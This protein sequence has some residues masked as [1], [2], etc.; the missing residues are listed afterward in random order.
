VLTLPGTEHTRHLFDERRLSLLEAHAV[1]VNVGRGS[2]LDT[3]ALIGALDARALRGAVLDVTDIEPLP[4]ESALWGR[5]NV[6]ISPHT[7]A[8]TTDEDAR[9]LALFAD[10]LRSFLAAEPLRNTIDLAAGY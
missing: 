6:I 4:A 2:V 9:I 3:G 1:L 7:A 8:L 10:N 5:P